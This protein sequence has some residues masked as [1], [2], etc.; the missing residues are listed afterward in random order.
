MT[1][2]LTAVMIFLS[3]FILPADFLIAFCIRQFE[4]PARVTSIMTARCNHVSTLW[5]H[6][7]VTAAIA[8]V[9]AAGQAQGNGSDPTVVE[10]QA[11]FSTVGNSLTI[12]NS[13]G[14]IINWQGFSIG[15]SETTTF[16]QQS[17]AS[18]VLN[19]VIG[20]DPSVILGTLT[21]NGRVF[22]INPSGILVGEGARIDVAGLT[23]S[24]L[25]LSNQDFLAG[26]LNFA[27]NPLAG[28]V[29]NQGSIT[30]P[31]GGSVY[32][33]GSNVT[34][35]GIINSP[36]GDVIL[37]AG[38]SVNIFDSSTPGVRVE[39]TA[40]DNAAV[41]LGEILAQSGEIGIYGAVLRNT[42]IINAD[43]VVRDASGKI[44]LRAKQDVTLEAG[45]SLSAN[46]EQGGE[47]TVQSET[48][49]TL[50][51][52]TIEAKGA[53]QTGGTVQVLG[54]KVGLIGG[55]I[56]A[57]GDAGGGTVLVGGDFQ[58]KNTDVQNASATYMSADSTI[59][60][61]AITNGSGGKVIVWADGI[62]RYYGHIS[63]LGGAQSGDGGFTEVS[64]K[65]N[66]VFDGYVDLRAPGGTTGTLL[67]DP[68]NITIQG[69]GPNVNGDG[70][71]GDDLNSA[72]SAPNIL[73]ADYG[74]SN[75]IIT[76]GQVVTQLATANVTLQA[77]NDIT[78]D[79]AIDAGGNAVGKA[80]TLQAGHDVIIH[81]ALTAA[82]VGGGSLI[83][84]AGNN[85]TV[86]AALTA[87][88]GSV[89]LSAGNNGTGPGVAGG[90]V[91]FGAVT[92]AN[93]SIRFNPVNYTTT[94]TEIDAY[95]AKATLTGT[96]DARAWL[97]VNN[98]S[99]TAQNKTYDST[100][101]AT[102]NTPFTFLSGP[103]G[104]SSGQIVSLSAGAA[105]F[106]SK[107]VATA[108]TVTFTGYGLIGTNAGLYSLFSQPA[109]QAAII[110][111][112][113]LA[114]TG[115]T[116][117]EKVY[118][119]T[120]TAT[121][122]GTAAITA[123]GSDI[124][125]LGGTASGAFADKNVGTGK[126]V[127][128]SGKTI[129]GTDSGNYNLVQQTGLTANIT[130]ADLAVTGL[131]ANDKVY[132]ANTAAI[133]G[134]AAA[135]T[136]LG[137]DNVILGGTASG[138]F[139]LKDVGIRAVTVAG[140]T[141]SG[142]DAGNYNLVQQTGLSANITPAA[143]GITANSTSKTYG[144]TVI[145]TGTEFSS[146]GLMN[147]ET[148]GSV[149]L[150]SE[151]AASTAAVAG[152]SYIITA[153][154]AG[155]GTF[156]A[157]N[158]TISY[159][160]G[161]LG[162]IRAA[163]GIAANSAT[164]LYG[165]ANP[166][167]SVT[168]TGFQ[169]GETA[170]ALTGTLTLTTPAVATSNVGNYAIAPSGF[171][172]SNYTITYVNGALGVTPAPLGIAANS[173]TRL[174]G[175][176]NPAFSATYT[177]F[178]NGETIAALTG[179]L[180]FATPAVLTS[181]VG[182]Y[183]IT[184]RGFSSSNYT[185]TYVNGT[186]GVTPAPLGIAAD[187]ASKIYGSTVSFTGAEFS[188][189][190]LMN[191]ET[192]G[193]V[194]LASARAV[195]TAGVTGGPY[196]ITASA[197]TGGTFNAD[198]YTISYVD[199]SLG[200]IPAALGI[201]ANSISKTY[202][203]TVTFTGTE[204][205]STGLMNGETIGSVSLVSEGA[206]STA[207]VTDSP[208][209]ITASAAG[210]GTF[211]SGNYTISYVDGSLGVIPAGLL[212]IAANAAAKTY[213]GLAY[214]GGNGVTYTGFQG[215]DTIADLSGT[216]VYGGSSQGAVNVGNYAIIPSGL[217]SSN[218][219]ITYVSGKLS[220]IPAP[221]GIAANSATRLYGDANPAFSA[222][223][224]GFKNGE[225]IAAL[226][227]TLA[228]TANANLTSNVGNYVITP[229]GLS[230]SNYTITYVNGKLGVTPAPLGIAAN[231][232]T[233][234]YGD[235]NPAF[236]ATYTGFK[237]GETIAALTGTLAITANANLTSNVGNYVITPSGLSSSNYTIAYVNG[238]LG[239][240]PAPLGIAANSA[241]KTYG[242]TVS[243]TG[244][245]FTSIGL[246]NG[247]T[248]GSVSLTSAGA[249]STAGVSDNP[250]DITAS[251]AGGGSFNAGNYTISYVNGSLGVIPAPLGIAAN[252]ATRLY[253]DANPAFSVTY[254]GFQNG[255]TTAALT[256][257]LTLATSANLTSN[258]GNYAITPIGLN[259][260][261]YTISYVNGKLSVTPAPLLITADAQSKLYGATDPA[262]TY[263]ASGLLFS[264][265][266]TGGLS[267]SVGENVG[268]YAINQ[269][270]L[271]NSNYTI[272]YTGSNL[273]IT[274]AILTV[275]A[276]AQT[277]VYGAT[278][279]ALTFSV[280][281]LVNNPALGIADTADSVFSGALTR[282]PGETVL[283]GP[284]AITQGTLT[285]NSNYFLGLFTGNIFTITSLGITLGVTGSITA[286]RGPIDAVTGDTVIY[287]GSTAF[288]SDK[289]PANAE[290]VTLAGLSLSDMDADNYTVNNTA[291][292]QANINPAL[293]GI[294][295][296]SAGTIP[297]VAP[298]ETPPVEPAPVAAAT[299][300]P[301]DEPAAVVVPT[302][303]PPKSYA[304][305][306]R[307]RKPD[308]N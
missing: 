85:V 178:K 256:G 50:V 115:L 61:D 101:A 265:T 296:N 49:T 48:G 164:R 184:P 143:L 147:G 166:A 305:P 213:D 275:L 285:T 197:A 114:V 276:N 293:P 248:I 230:S 134:G 60:V 51:S 222:T 264:D 12:T 144:S 205:T 107:D 188:S 199:G 128:V 217:S 262:L 65:N 78:V 193:S 260:T 156:N 167:F 232:S 89:T 223:Y 290:T 95:R 66:L 210:G 145:F 225:T 170:A 187:S 82:S 297:V 292:N 269:G 189:T 69:A 279:P 39:I 177:G 132:N 17:S 98:S 28:K 110:T 53:G 93:L 182:N 238:N 261:N 141:I 211:N 308:R 5:R 287:T 19:R 155:G 161:T 75:S 179:A 34:N 283:G 121:L 206:A 35:S 14:A 136:A 119:T 57:S 286:I 255:E 109:S 76:T 62:T 88:G 108:T 234:L 277:K 13:P 295:E 306:Q 195:S 243:F 194:S 214:S 38:E 159:V 111:K 186:L 131:T 23:A 200:V 258:V 112:A 4:R 303:T 274:P 181:N 55:H 173:A 24:T 56:N 191:G 172:S 241:S 226:T 104:A 270:T 130:K 176:A 251:A 118:D 84:S 91:T 282:V 37:A 209:D 41:N 158:Y 54:D 74:V 33:V 257:A 43:Q 125:T 105:N 58:G 281:G 240:T 21:S 215:S 229:I 239:V 298:D 11:G 278:D 190:G 25:N 72:V 267:R 127:T 152:S 160:N 116:A 99:A 300:T 80:L 15:A 36:Q 304:P 153:S 59:T 6:I 97:F 138:T 174:Y 289:N 299:Q 67:L 96:Y 148:V 169:N 44:V 237:N 68:Y 301:P 252:S 30:T 273:G 175:D 245:E 26:R 27:S 3:L 47:I 102:L 228:I 307:P 9:F 139:A 10:G 140:N 212:G 208:Y 29:E 73:F 22:L 154:A 142:T 135:I 244:T 171:S 288:F 64:G 294:A 220:V 263:I 231:S 284:Y 120:L 268:S 123:L 92:A 196:D 7:A 259:S 149:S 18:S 254:T 146:T 204:F 113:N 133:L 221:L 302:E 124:V 63:A 1:L 162:V 192:I 272:S 235:A 103:D 183:A 2:E 271:A 126:A 219:T 86:G 42:G 218:Y 168:Y 137:T 81:A 185:I 236:S 233:R 201:A 246:K 31:S 20:P 280:T 198:N 163:L 253:G 249:A 83:L 71:A 16:I 106:N 227:G 165:D 180:A 250:Y 46:G 70:V 79:A 8:C 291:A 32:L 247:E 117:G 157:A 77:N 40:S 207:D 129:S 266:L 52:G 150:V 151:G 122:G 216:L 87:S 242:T 45:S 100:T 203:A 94:I 224:T 90:T 202:G